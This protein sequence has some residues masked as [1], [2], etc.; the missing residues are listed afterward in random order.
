MRTR[1]EQRA[2]RWEASQEAAAASEAAAIGGIAGDEGVDPSQRPLVEGGEGV[3]E[4]FELAEQELI[5]AAQHTDRRLTPLRD[6]F[7]PEIGGYQ[8]AAYGEGDHEESS[9]LKEDDR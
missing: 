1:A 3:A 2:A 4:G 7:P 9:E 8:L 6:A 5:D